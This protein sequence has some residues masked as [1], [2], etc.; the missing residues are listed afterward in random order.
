MGIFSRKQKTDIPSAV[1]VNPDDF[2]NERKPPAKK[3]T[4]VVPDKQL[5]ESAQSKKPE[6]F[7]GPRAISPEV[8]EKKSEE[9]EAE[10]AQ[11]AAEKV[12]CHFEIPA[13]GSVDAAAIICDIEQAKEQKAEKTAWGAIRQ[14]DTSELEAKVWALSEKYAY[15]CDGMNEQAC[16]IAGIS[17]E[18]IERRKADFDFIRASKQ[19]IIVARIPGLTQKQIKMIEQFIADDVHAEIPVIVNRIPELSQEVIDRFIGEFESRT[20][21]LSQTEP[22]I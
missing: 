22:G 9:L 21:P 5:H 1:L 16:V 15:L 2:W 7:N 14:A 20:V 6:I 12:H 4:P 10:L 8:L 3:E 11:K 17:P 19:E 13:A 18:E